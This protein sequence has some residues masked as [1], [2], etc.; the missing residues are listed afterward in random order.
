MR[1]V[2]KVDDQLQRGYQ[3]KDTGEDTVGYW[4]SQNRSI[5]FKKSRFVVS[6]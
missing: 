1:I 2:K 6:C 3:L 4:C 5:A